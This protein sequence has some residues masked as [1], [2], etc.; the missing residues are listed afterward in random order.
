[1]ILG[2]YYVGIGVWE[3]CRNNLSIMIRTRN[4]ELYARHNLIFLDIQQKKIDSYT[5]IELKYVMHYS[6]RTFF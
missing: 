5:L 2:I 1:M 4:L 6:N 3:L